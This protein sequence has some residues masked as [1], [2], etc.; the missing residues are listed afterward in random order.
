[1]ALGVWFSLEAS[2][3]E[4]TEKLFQADNKPNAAPQRYCTQLSELFT[5]YKDQLKPYIHV[6]HANTHGLCKG[7]TTKASSDTMCPPAQV[8]SSAARGKW[9][10]EH[11]LD[12]YWHFAEPGG[13]FPGCILAGLDPS[14]KEF[15]CSL[16]TK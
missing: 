10:L 6:E 13:T 2:H 11:A 15:G 7:G 12:L 1:L 4:D 9:S 5:Q 16:E 14:F 3:F 8:S